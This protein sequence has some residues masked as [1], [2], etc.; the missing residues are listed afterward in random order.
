MSDEI[1]PLLA[2]SDEQFAEGLVKL[3]WFQYPPTLTD[4][5][6]RGGARLALS[7]KI[8]RAGQVPDTGAWVYRMTLESSHQWQDAIKAAESQ[9][10]AEPQFAVVFV[11][12]PQK[13]LIL[14]PEDPDKAL[15]QRPGIRMGQI[16]MNTSRPG[17]YEAEIIQRLKSAKSQGFRARLQEM[18]NV[19][20]VTKKFYDEFKVQKDAFIAFIC[21]I[22]TLEDRQ[23]YA[24]VLLNR[25]MFIYFL[26]RG[27]DGDG[28]LDRNPE[29]LASHLQKS[30]ASFYREFLLPLFFQG[31][32]V[33]Q[34]QRP[35]EVQELLGEIP[36]LNGGLFLEHKLEK[37]YPAITIENEAF[38]RLFQ[39][40][41]SYTWHI[42][43]RPLSA[44]RQINPDVLGFIFEKY[45]NQKQMGAYYTKEDIT[46]YICRNTVIPRLFDMLEARPWFGGQT[47]KDLSPTKQEPRSMSYVQKVIA[48]TLAK[49]GI[50]T[51]L[52]EP[53]K[54]GV[55]LPLPD[56]IEAGV[57][58]VAERGRWNEAAA[59]EY[60]L[61]TETWRE[62]V[63]RRQRYESV[64]EDYRN[65]K[66]ASINDFITYNL[67][68]ERFAAD[69]IHGLSN[70]H[71]LHYFYFRCLQRI[72]VLDPTC[73]S[74]AFLF[75]ALNIL[76]P[77]YEAC[78][79]RMKQL[80]G[81]NL[82]TS[83][84]QG[85]IMG[86]SSVINEMDAQQSLW[87]LNRNSNP[88]LA[89]CYDEFARIARHPN[90]SYYIHKTI[91]VNN[92]HG[93]DIMEEAVE[94]CKLRLFLNLMSH[95]EPNDSM[96]NH[97]IEPLPDIDFNILSGNT[98][99][100][101]TSVADIDRQW[102]AV[103]VENSTLA[104]EKD[105]SQ[106]EMMVTEYGHKIELFRKQ[107]LGEAPNMPLQTKED[108]QR[109]CGIIQPELDEDIWRLYR[110]AGR[111]D[112]PPKKR[113]QDF[114]ASHQPFHWFLQFPGVM[115]GGGFDAIVGNPP[116]VKRSKLV[117]PYLAL[118]LST[119][120]CPD[121]Y[122]DVMAR[123]KQI[124]TIGMH[125]G[126]IV[127]LSL[128][129]SGQFKAL[130]QELRMGFTEN[131]FSAYDI[132]PAAI[133]D[134][135]DQR[136]IIWLGQ[137]TDGEAAAFRTGPLRR[138]KSEYRSSLMS[139]LSY[140]ITDFE[141][142]SSDDIPKFSGPM[143][144][145]IYENMNSFK[146]KVQRS[147]GKFEAPQLP[148]IPEATTAKI[149][150]SQA[151]R[152]FISVF[153]E[154]PPCIDAETLTAVPA[155]K[156]GWV[157]FPAETDIY[158][159]IAVCCGELFFWYW[160]V[161]GDGFDVTLWFFQDFLLSFSYDEN[162]AQCLA[163]LGRLLH[164]R[165]N[166]ALRFSRCAGKY[167]GNYNY[168]SLAEITRRADL[169]SIATLGLSA[170]HAQE[171][172]DYVERV[173][174]INVNAGEKAIPAEIKLQYPIKVMDQAVIKS[175]FNRTDALICERLN[176]SSLEL[177]ALVSAPVQFD[178]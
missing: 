120:S 175:V 140:T 159:H 73:G 16:F 44:E 147:Q 29:Y 74:G 123:S 14:A 137:Q 45:V 178:T 118:G 49:H 154:A 93:V 28:L 156:I 20:R 133:F 56:Y 6:F 67:D 83:G 17:N 151:A 109:A 174:A 91:I 4:H 107:Q 131:W 143:Q 30:A 76:Y 7:P 146:N 38:E 9:L 53:V 42:D 40:F 144:R 75:A 101:Y 31:F 112:D 59:E 15:Q 115:A 138:W 97:G 150:F 171:I 168:R 87:N 90:P 98:L 1:L 12:Y 35:A 32:A 141:T 132:R 26:Q 121:I 96:P 111:Y 18:V 8:L 165:R 122:S 153:I 34:N 25:L 135:V 21:G 155:S 128:A 71:E 119:E 80:A 102:H 164:E 125:A 81:L 47:P 43:D 54:K 24:S 104:F 170:L 103:E 36:Y 88:A 3:G 160:L 158:P 60:A 167:V 169:L 10:R 161:R 11:T 127:P 55:E 77:L 106:L 48:G 126:M 84:P 148:P 50:E 172:F 89:E 63:A 46:G 27:V 78:L 99:V 13:L 79:V 142:N 39:F 116:Y 117:P 152:N 41:D 157:S 145:Y 19:E 82:I 58:A 66:I 68:I 105:H 177:K 166:E 124:G 62:H 33:P 163:E 86:E 129:F 85:S 5:P 114:I 52:Y 95:A 113:K 149:G 37:D 110:T 65:G 23:W 2:G 176:I 100:G 139:T 22:E 136:C 61:P 70:A 72:T 173:R 162:L 130:R 64:L 69:F 92:L 57:G 94:I 51:Y 134:G 108:V